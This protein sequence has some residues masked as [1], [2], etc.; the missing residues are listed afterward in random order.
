MKQIVKFIIIDVDDPNK[1]PEKYVPN[2]S[3]GDLLGMAE[4][5]MSALVGA[6]GGT[7]TFKLIAQKPGKDY[8]SVTVLTEQIH[9]ECRPS[10]RLCFH[11]L[12]LDLARKDGPLGKSDPYLVF[13]RKRADGSE[14]EVLRTEVVKNNLNPSWQDLSVSMVKLCNGDLR[15]PIR[16][17]CI[18]W[19]MM[20]SHDSIGIVDTCVADLLEHKQLTLQDKKG[21][22]GQKCGILTS[23]RARILRVPEFLDYI[24]EGVELFLTVAVDFTLSNGAIDEPSS[25]HY[26]DPSGAWNPY[27]QVTV[28]HL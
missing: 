4:S 16:I 21:R 20:S 14:E 11:M 2:S 5:P 17:E 19:D 18:D 12:G 13:S 8:G 27:Q 26:V 28:H 25:L 9:A 23:D 7:S 3:E 22:S 15:G 24:T 1:V 6:R 10:D